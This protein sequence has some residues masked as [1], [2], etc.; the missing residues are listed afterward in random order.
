M[1]DKM[2]QPE[3]K[4]FGD[5]TRQDLDR[6]PVWIACHLA[7]YDEPWYDDTD[8]ETFRPYTGALPADVPNGM[9]LVKATFALADGSS[10]P[11]FLTPASEP[12]DIGTQQPYL[13]FG[14]QCFSF[15]GGIVGISPE[16]RQSL[17]IALGKTPAEI[18]PLRFSVDPA[19]AAGHT[20]G[21]LDGFYRS[22]ANGTEIEL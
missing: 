19:L 7:D 21:R 16:E 15:W 5:L 11:G 18:F 22:L 17:Y 13:F 8:E 3:L 14:D 4:Q 9:L 12:G 6:H 20:S 1:T 10:Y 2:D